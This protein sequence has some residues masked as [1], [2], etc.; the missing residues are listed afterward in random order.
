MVVFLK[1]IQPYYYYFNYSIFDICNNMVETRSSAKQNTNTKP[2]MYTKSMSLPAN[3]TK[4][5]E[6][7]IAGKGLFAQKDIK[8]FQLV[9]T[10]NK[11]ITV[12]YEEYKKRAYDLELRKNTGISVSKNKMIINKQFSS[13]DRA[14]KWYRINHSNTPN[15]KM[16]ELNDDGIGWYALK[17]IPKD[18][19]LFFKYEN[20]SFDLPNRKEYFQRSNI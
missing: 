17:N 2:K 3:Y 10:M 12:S 11:G 8:R 18:T 20:P 6:S 7:S 1:L 9:I 4:V 14:P 16:V 15:L 5:K 19:E 13:M